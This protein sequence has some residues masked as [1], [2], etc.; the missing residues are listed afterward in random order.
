MPG[1]FQDVAQDDLGRD[2]VVVAHADEG[3]L[4]HVLAGDGLQAGQRLMFGRR[5]AGASGRQ[6]DVGGN[7]L[8]IRV[9]RARRPDGGSMR[10]VWRHRAEVAADEVV[11]LFERGRGAGRSV[12]DMGKLGSCCSREQ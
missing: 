6:A 2:G 4:Q 1:V 12:F 3:L 5:F 9:S 7:G 8:S 10:R 11:A